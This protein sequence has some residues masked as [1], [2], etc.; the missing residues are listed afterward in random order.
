MERIK[1]RHTFGILYD[2]NVPPKLKGMFYIVVIR[3]IYIVRNRVLADQDLSYVEDESS[4]NEN[5][6]MNV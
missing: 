1:W 4:G 5:I 2:K 3:L 6:E